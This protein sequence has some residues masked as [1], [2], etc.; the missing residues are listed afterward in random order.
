MVLRPVE[1]RG[2]VQQVCV[3]FLTVH[4]ETVSPS[5]KTVGSMFLKL[6]T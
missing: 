3:D 1:G 2:D 4:G 5:A 6:A